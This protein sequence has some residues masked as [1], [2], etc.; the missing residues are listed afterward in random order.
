MGDAEV[1]PRGERTGKRHKRASV[2]DVCQMEWLGSVNGHEREAQSALRAEPRPGWR[3]S[4]GG[5]AKEMV[6]L[7]RALGGNFAHLKSS[8]GK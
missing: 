1:H 5:Y 8:E 2:E 6:V 7:G 4:A 3:G